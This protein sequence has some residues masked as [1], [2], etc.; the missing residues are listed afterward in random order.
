MTDSEFILGTETFEEFKKL[1]DSFAEGRR[2]V[3]RISTWIIFSA[4]FG[5]ALFSKVVQTFLAIPTWAFI[6][7][8]GTILG[9]FMVFVRRK[10]EDSIYESRFGKR[11]LVAKNLAQRCGYPW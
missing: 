7:C 9:V 4:A 10:L 6:L 1:K 3:R 11:E 8:F 5:L 2:S